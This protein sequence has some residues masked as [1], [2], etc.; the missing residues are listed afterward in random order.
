M[1]TRVGL[2]GTGVRERVD[3]NNIERE[4]G[5]KDFSIERRN[6]ITSVAFRR[7]Y[8]CVG[9]SPPTRRTMYSRH[10]RRHHGPVLTTRI[11]KLVRFFVRSK[12][13]RPS[14][15]RSAPASVGGKYFSAKR[16]ERAALLQFDVRPDRR[17]VVGMFSIIRSVNLFRSA[18]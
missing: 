3:S 4:P 2:E 8:Y 11:R 5:I 15:S 10:I 16:T 12:Q 7:P 1:I 18:Q 6:V 9:R 13:T 14:C 17:V